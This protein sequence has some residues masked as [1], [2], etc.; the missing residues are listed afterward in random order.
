MV[1]RLHHCLADG[2]AGVEIMNELLGTVS[3]A[4]RVT[5]RKRNFRK[6]PQLNPLT[7]L[8]DGWISS[9]G[10]LV[11]GSLAA[12]SEVAN[13]AGRMFVDS[14]SWPAAEFS[15]LVPEL[16]VPTEPLH[17]NVTYRGPQK[18]AWTEIPLSDVK[19]IRHACGVSVN[20]VVLALVTMTIRRYA[21]M[22]RNPIRKRLLRMMVPVN[23]R[24]NGN[25]ADLGNR[26][27]LLPVTVP[28][29]IRNPRRLLLAVHERTEFLK[30]AHVAELVGLAGTLLGMIATPLQALLGPFASQLPVAPFNLVCTNVPGPQFPLYLLG[31]KMLQWYPYVPVG[32]EMTLNCAI[33]SYN[34]TMY[35]G[36]SG[37]SQAAPDLGRLTALLRS[38]LAQLGKAVHVPTTRT[39]KARRVF[40]PS[41]DHRDDPAP[42]TLRM[43]I[44]LAVSSP[45]IESPMAT[46]PE[47]E[48]VL[49]PANA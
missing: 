29:D 5:K 19:A 48:G 14:N 20:D 40:H 30:R 10:N 18:Y 49:E 38:N 4:P 34:G 2:I 23:L 39:T 28:L 22:H 47:E 12:Q 41:F 26:I 37:C 21:E 3:S 11:Q 44:P 46:S 33:L 15:K 43:T 13:I 31:H 24:G 25:A 42:E 9:C 36:F 45:T 35:F 1:F 6:P 7:S 16:T 27:S 17:F 8:L 32:G